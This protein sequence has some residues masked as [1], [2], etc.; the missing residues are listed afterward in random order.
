VD[1]AVTVFGRDTAVAAICTPDCFQQFPEDLADTIVWAKCSCCSVFLVFFPIDD[2]LFCAQGRGKVE[3]KY[4]GSPCQLAILQTSLSRNSRNSNNTT[5]EV[6]S[7]EL[8]MKFLGA[9]VVLTTGFFS[10]ISARKFELYHSVY[11]TMK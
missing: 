8:R 7:P 11:S 9:T 2:W 5:F 4:I 3:N 10:I 6:R 1:F